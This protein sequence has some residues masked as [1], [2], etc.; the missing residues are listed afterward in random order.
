MGGVLACREIVPLAWQPAVLAELPPAVAEQNQRVIAAVAALAERTRV[1]PETP[2][3]AEFE[4]LH[5]KFDLMLELLGA[6]LRSTQGLPPAT[7]VQ[8]SSEGLRWTPD[9]ALPQVGTHLDVS[10]YLH[11]CAPAPLRWLGTVSAVEGGEIQLRWLPMPEALQSV[12]EQHVFI[13]HRR[14]VADARSPVCR[15]EV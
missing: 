1:E 4:R 8:L 14:S 2:G 13:R 10:L 11:P 7:P 15:G 12:L 3:A 6:L 9:A 5:L